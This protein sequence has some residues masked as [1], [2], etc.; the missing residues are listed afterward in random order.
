M[1]AARLLPA[2]MLA[3]AAKYTEDQLKAGAVE[4]AIQLRHKYGGEVRGEP[5]LRSSA[6]RRRR[7]AAPPRRTHSLQGVQLLP[8]PPTPT[9]QV[10]VRLRLVM[11]GSDSQRI[12]LAIAQRLE[13]TRMMLAV[14][15]KGRLVYANTGLASLLGYKLAALK[16]RELT[17]L[18]P[19]P[20]SILH[21]KLI[22]AR[23]GGGGRCLPRTAAAGLWVPHLRANEEF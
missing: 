21:A 15:H 10:G 9:H 22:K 8:C 16:G 11:G 18:L 2:R 6:T 13:E 17:T 7:V 12:L 14:D 1:G 5:R 23:G 3:S 4:A 19:P 20:Y